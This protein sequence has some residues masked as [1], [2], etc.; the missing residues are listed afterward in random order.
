MMN[1]PPLGPDPS[2]MSRDELIRQLQNARNEIQQLRQENQQL[3]GNNNNNNNFNN[4]NNNRN[5]FGGGGNG[6]NPNSRPSSANS[7]T[8]SNGNS[9]NRFNQMNGKQYSV[10]MNVLVISGT[11]DHKCRTLPLETVLQKGNL[12]RQQQ[13][14]YEREADTPI[15]QMMA[16]N[17]PHQNPYKNNNNT[18]TIPFLVIL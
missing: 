3:G 14:G 10:S 1:R 12:Q 11:A 9:F 13:G 2:Q 8:S 6:S 16:Q 5:S 4:N 18:K 17:A 15:N 7:N